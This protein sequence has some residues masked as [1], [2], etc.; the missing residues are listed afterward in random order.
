MGAH[1]PIED[2]VFLVSGARGV[3]AKC[4]IGMAEKFKSKFILWKN[5]FSLS[6]PF[7]L[8]VR[9]MKLLK[10]AALNWLKDQVPVKSLKR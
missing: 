4:V 1:K 2:S 6:S 7:G 10:K 9:S 8:K 5:K 3:T